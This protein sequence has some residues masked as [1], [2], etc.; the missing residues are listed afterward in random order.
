MLIALFFGFFFVPSGAS[1][2][3]E[4]YT[5]SGHAS[6]PEAWTGWTSIPTDNAGLL[7][8]PSGWMVISKDDLPE[9]RPESETA[10]RILN[11]QQVLCAKPEGASAD[12]GVVLQVFSMW[13]SDGSGMA[14]TLPP[15][16]LVDSEEP[17]VAGLLNA[18]YGQVRRAGRDILNTELENISITMWETGP[19]EMRYRSVALFHGEKLVLVLIRYLPEH[20]KYWKQQFETIVNQWVASLSLTPRPVFGASALPP[21][22]EV[23]TELSPVVSSDATVAA[24]PEST[25]EEPPSTSKPV[26]RTPVLS[27]IEEIPALLE[28]LPAPLLYAA[29]AGA[30]AFLLCAL[31]LIR[32]RTRGKSPPG[33]EGED[34]FPVLPVDSHEESLPEDS[35]LEGSWKESQSEESPPEELQLEESRLEEPQTGEMLSEMQPAAVAETLLE[36]AAKDAAG[37]ASMGFEGVY[38]L[39]NQALDTIDSSENVVSLP[40]YYSNMEDD[41][42]IFAPEREWDAEERDREEGPFPAGEGE[43][44]PTPEPSR[45]KIDEEIDDVPAVSGL[46]AFYLAAFT[47]MALGDLV[48]SLFFANPFDTVLF[49]GEWE[50]I[51]GPLGNGFALMGLSCLWAPLLRFAGLRRPMKRGIFSAFAALLTTAAGACSFFLSAFFLFAVPPNVTVMRACAMAAG[52]CLSYLTLTRRKIGMES[53]EKIP[54]ELEIPR[55]APEENIPE[56]APEPA[57]KEPATENAILIETEPIPIDESEKRRVVEFAV[58]RAIGIFADMERTEGPSYALETLKNKVLEI[59]SSEGG[60]FQILQAQELT[61]DLQPDCFILQLSG[62]ILLGLIKTGRYHVGRGILSSEGEELAG[63]FRGVVERLTRNRCGRPDDSER[64]VDM[65][66]RCIDALG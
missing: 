51:L 24:L 50:A 54:E 4:R 65:M 48:T 12:R 11:V 59:L 8:L 7:S 43:N 22:P 3:P 14:F 58:R 42:P 30:V 36:P 38:T 57:I 27:Y 34:V 47:L 52:V 63:I 25:R 16:L 39:L 28:I 31:L 56:R 53:P 41:P 21:L 10:G 46:L 32:K 61:A 45:P 35:Q 13:S 40:R 66:R 37:V 2:A 64:M 60:A 19:S 6:E 33:V 9:Q 20:E 1:A 17:L 55:E 15:E 5:L 44:A 18:R 62:R 49:P 23:V 29:C 26:E